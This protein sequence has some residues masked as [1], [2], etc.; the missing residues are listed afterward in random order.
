VATAL[1]VAG[2]TLTF[3]IP[4]FASLSSYSTV[5]HVVQSAYDSFQLTHR[6]VMTRCSII[7]SIEPWRHY[8]AH[9]HN[10]A[11]RVSFDT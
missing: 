10:V 7:W 3:W 8:S 5:V 2:P 11:T 1:L 9:A 4:P 6:H